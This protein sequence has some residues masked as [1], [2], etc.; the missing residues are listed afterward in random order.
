M[1]Q[2]AFFPAIMVLVTLFT[3]GCAGNDC[4]NACEAAK[5]CTQVPARWAL[6]ECGEG[7]DFYDNQA[8]T[9][10]CTA[11]LDTLNACGADNTDRACEEN[12]CSAEAQALST[13]LTK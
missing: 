1:K 12:V 7:C 10:E 9:A 8:S 3:A 6:F 4:E 13:C 5:M 11:E 2:R